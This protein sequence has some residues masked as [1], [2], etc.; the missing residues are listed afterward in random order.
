MQ[1]TALFTLAAVLVSFLTQAAVTDTHQ[2]Y[3]EPGFDY[4]ANDIGNTTSSTADG[5]CAKC[6]ATTGCRAY[7]W[8]DYNGGTC[9]LKRGRG[10]IVVNSNVQS[11]T[12]QPLENPDG[13][14]GCQLDEGIDYVGND[15]GNVRM[16]KPL[17]CCSSCLHFPGC[18]AF[19]FTTYNG[20]TCWLKSAKG[21][22]VVN[23]E[24]RSAQ[25][26]LEAPSCGLEYDI[27]YVGNDIGSASASKP[28]DC[29]DV[30]SRKD[31]C[32]AFSWTDQNGGTCWLK[33]RKDGTISKK[34]VTS[35]QVKA[36][37]ASPS[38]AL[39]L[40]VDYKGNDIGNA[41]S[42]DPYACCS[43]CMAKSGCNAFSWSNYNGGTCWFKSAKGETESKVGV[44]SAIV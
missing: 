2:C 36:N 12:L 16:L 19:T 34:G 23:P 1:V 24:A 41:P 22:M 44:K 15:I 21:P 38:C 28:Q 40:D 27:D 5:C 4:V 26:Y 3:V 43:K 14:G 29:C 17:G 10:T 35:A 42:S 37:P 18:R 7:S 20:G 25:P 30:C 8:T 9:W 6:E 13:T 11:A 32:R 39:E 33:N 31:G